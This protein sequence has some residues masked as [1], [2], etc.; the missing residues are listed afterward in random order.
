MKLK[1]LRIE[2]WV[3]QARH[4]K[5]TVPEHVTQQQV[6]EFLESG[7]Y[8]DDTM[9]VDDDPWNRAWVWNDTMVEVPL[10]K[11]A[12]TFINEFKEDA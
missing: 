11:T 2:A 8:P 12:P 1:T 3:D 9:T 4:G 6:F 10:D 7:Y 5:I